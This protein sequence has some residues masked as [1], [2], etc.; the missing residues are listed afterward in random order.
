MNGGMRQHRQTIIFVPLG[1]SSDNYENGGECYY[2]GAKI[3]KPRRIPPEMEE[4][5]QIA[6]R[7]VRENV[8]TRKLSYLGPRPTIASLSLGVTRQLRVRQILP[9]QIG[10][11]E[12]SG[13]ST[14]SQQP[15]NNESTISRV[16]NKDN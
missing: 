9:T 5:R 16:S 4:V 3:D 1:F 14:T 12:A 15:F 13:H 2:N 10:G 6:Q 7:I 8:C 11:A